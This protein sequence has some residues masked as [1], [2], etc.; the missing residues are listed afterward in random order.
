MPYG[1]SHGWLKERKEVGTVETFADSR[2]AARQ[3]LY[4]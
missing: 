4:L 2:Y 3:Q 1:Y